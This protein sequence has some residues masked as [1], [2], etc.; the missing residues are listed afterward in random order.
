MKLLFSLYD[1]ARD[2]FHAPC[3]FLDPDAAKAAFVHLCTD[4]SIQP[5][6][7]P[8][9]F[10]LHLLGAYDEETGE[11]LSDGKRQRIMRGADLV[12][13]PEESPQLIEA[14]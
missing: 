3:V 8:V 9:D 10:E 12:K 1:A 13:T 6:Q 2:Y 7:R 14:A 5:G 11:L 4:G